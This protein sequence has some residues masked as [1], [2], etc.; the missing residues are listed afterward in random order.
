MQCVSC[1]VT[2]GNKTVTLNINCPSLS[3]F[4]SFLVLFFCFLFYYI[5]GPVCSKPCL[6]S[7]CLHSCM[8]PGQ[9]CVCGPRANQGFLRKTKV[10]CG[11][12]L[13]VCVL[14]HWCNYN[15]VCFFCLCIC[16][17]GCV[18]VCFF[19]LDLFGRFRVSSAHSET[20]ESCYSDRT[21]LI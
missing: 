10:F 1:L 13:G 20:K 18:S 7:L 4:M 9:Y 5:K 14:V 8:R 2:G 3:T 12:K 11:R 6:L 15:W 19:V 17:C 16:W 21:Q